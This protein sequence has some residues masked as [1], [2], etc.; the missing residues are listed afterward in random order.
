MNAPDLL[1]VIDLA[2][3]S[4]ARAG[5][6]AADCVLVESDSVEARVRDAEI[7]FVKQAR[8]RTLGIR[9]LVGGDR[10]KS[11]AITSTSDLS[12]AAVTRMASET[13]ALARATRLSA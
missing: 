12:E 6:D 1:A 3:E 13:V 8:E 7:D 9:A 10:G 11:S 5:A 2:L 4:V